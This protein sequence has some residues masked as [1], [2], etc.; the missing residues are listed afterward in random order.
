L[1]R[2]AE[3]LVWA[4]RVAEAAAL[5]ERAGDFV[6]AARLFERAANEL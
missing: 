2:Q 1:L 5:V 4:G 3:R 6:R